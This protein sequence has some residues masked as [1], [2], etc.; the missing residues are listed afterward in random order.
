M[1]EK[2]VIAYFK[3]PEDA[4][5][6]GD[7]LKALGVQEIQIDEFGRYPDSGL[8]RVNPVT[9][10]IPS[11]A[12]LILGDRPTGDFGALAAADA[13][14]SGLSDKGWDPTDGHNIILTAVMNEALHQEALQA[15]RQAGGLA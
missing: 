9:G 12:H 1:A 11:Q 2:S 8:R 13:S 5:R 7:E 10:R 3:N 15:V 4:A 14:V 6:A